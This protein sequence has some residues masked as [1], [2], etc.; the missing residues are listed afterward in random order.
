DSAEPDDSAAGWGRVFGDGV[1]EFVDGWFRGHGEGD[2][3][4]WWYPGL[5]R[6][7]DVAG[8]HECHGYVVGVGQ[9]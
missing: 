6:E 4:F 7:C 5:E 8:W 1:G 3:W 2:C 9:W